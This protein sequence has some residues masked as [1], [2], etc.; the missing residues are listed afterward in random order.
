[1]VSG[2]AIP[3]PR[4]IAHVSGGRDFCRPT[5]LEPAWIQSVTKPVPRVAKRAPRPMNDQMQAPGSEPGQTR[6]SSAAPHR[7]VPGHRNPA[8]RPIAPRGL[9]FAESARYDRKTVNTIK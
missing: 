9:H 8:T 2:G 6:G 3:G 1:V 5:S 4:G 7:F